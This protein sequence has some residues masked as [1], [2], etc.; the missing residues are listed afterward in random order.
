[1]LLRAQAWQT[2]GAGG[3]APSAASALLSAC[4]P[5]NRPSWH[6]RALG[7]GGVA[8]R[9]PPVVA[10]ARHDAPGHVHGDALGRDHGQRPQQARG[11]LDHPLHV[12]AA[13]LFGASGG[14]RGGEGGSL[15]IRLH[16]SNAA[17]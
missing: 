2:S 1:M 12:D 4:A 9:H 16:T 11:E 5:P 14:V 13:L 10:A 6:R 17:L 15:G 3:G 7:A 8:S